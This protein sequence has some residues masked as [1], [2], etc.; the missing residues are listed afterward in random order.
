MKARFGV[1]FF[2]PIFKNPGIYLLHGILGYLKLYSTTDSVV[3]L[4]KKIGFKL[5]LKSTYVSRR[6][7]L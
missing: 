6:P 5:T 2:N 3:R 1:Q 4:P 7:D